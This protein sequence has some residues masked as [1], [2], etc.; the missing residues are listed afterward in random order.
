[1]SDNSLAEALERCF[2]SPNESDSNWE[3]A[4]IVDGLFFIGRAI[5]K[6]ADIIEAQPE[7]LKPRPQ[8]PE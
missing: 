6:L 1:M 5:Y 4:N 3:V 8:P 2:Q 7:R